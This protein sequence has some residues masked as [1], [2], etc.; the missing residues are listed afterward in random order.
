MAI[1]A[2]C[3]NTQWQHAQWGGQE[4]TPSHRSQALDSPRLHRLQQAQARAGELDDFPWYSYRR[5]FVP[6]TYEGLQ[7]PVYDQSVTW[8]Y[9]SQDGGGRAHDYFNS[10][11]YRSRVT[12]TVH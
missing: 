8:T 2:G 9:D 6:T 5:D 7:G 3:Q 11:T 1:A 12:E 10:T 4:V